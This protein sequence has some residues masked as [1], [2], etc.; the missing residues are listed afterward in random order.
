M[1]IVAICPV[2]SDT[3]STVVASPAPGYDEIAQNSQVLARRFRGFRVGF[4]Q[5]VRF[6]TKGEA[7]W[8][9]LSTRRPEAAGFR[10]QARYAH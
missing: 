8:A 1:M 9:T 10:P 5:N 2:S 3:A 4:L 6:K 7:A